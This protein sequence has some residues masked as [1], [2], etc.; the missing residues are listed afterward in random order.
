M[1]HAGV[2]QRHVGP[3]IPATYTKHPGPYM[4]L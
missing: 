1:I 4:R 2:G 3:L